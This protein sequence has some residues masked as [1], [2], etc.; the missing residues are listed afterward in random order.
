V[1][2]E[3]QPGRGRREQIAFEAQTFGGAAGPVGLSLSLVT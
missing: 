1:R 2:C 3:G